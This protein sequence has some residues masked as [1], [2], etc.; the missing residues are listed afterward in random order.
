MT[1]A[2]PALVLA[3]ALATV[4]PTDVAG[5]LAALELRAAELQAL[6][7]AARAS[8]PP[9]QGAHLE[10]EL[11]F[12]PELARIRRDVADHEIRGKLVFG[13]LLGQK[14]FLQVAA[15]AIAGVELAATDAELLGHVGVL[16]QL[17]DVEIWPLAV[18]RRVAARGGGLARAAV[19][20]LATLCTPRLSGPP[21]GG[22]M[23]FLDRVDAARA[24]GRP[25][26]AT[27]DEIAASRERIQGLGR[28]VLGA[29]ERVPHQLALNAR[30]GRDRG[31]SVVLAQ[32]IDAW[33]SSKK[34]VRVNSAGMHGALLRD[35]G[36]SPAA[37]AAFSLL[38]FI[39]P[40]LAQ[41]VF[42]EEHGRGG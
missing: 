23:R 36:F 32:A 40:V 9:R 15:Y 31:E 38:Y 8:G 26:E 10:P 18:V 30:Y 17:A 4:G 22:F 33:F 28:P 29:D 21:V 1:G 24:A 6:L 2:E 42:S 34:G 11:C 7:D 27:L 14:S 19:A 35:L 12:S 41:A 39:V 16:T 13:E 20:G 37:G 5:A 3:V 25:L